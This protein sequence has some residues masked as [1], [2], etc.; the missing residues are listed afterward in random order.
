[1]QRAMAFR[2]LLGRPSQITRS[3]PAPAQ[4]ILPQVAH[5]SSEKG[6]EREAHVQVPIQLYGVH[7]RYASSLYVVA[8]RA[9]MLEPIHQE[10]K[11]VVKALKESPTFIQFNDDASVPEATRVK[12]V[13][14]IFEELGFSEISVNFLAILAENDR[15]RELPKIADKFSE[16]FMAYK[17]EVKAC[18]TVAHPLSPKEMDQL[19]DSLKRYVKPG[20]TILMDQKVD[21]SVLGGLVVEIGD[22]Y[23]DISLATQL[24]KFQKLLSE[25]D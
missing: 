8:T 20:D 15:L 21:R 9:N 25:A 4:R 13:R 14:D 10:L 24:K 12:V 22:K 1:M 5:F 18:V 11:E 17:G 16:L 23:I 6:V 2:R 7:G 3:I 19:K